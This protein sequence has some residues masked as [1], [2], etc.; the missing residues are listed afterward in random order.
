M[1]D[2][3]T[4]AGHKVNKIAAAGAGIGLAV[5][6]IYLYRRHQASAAAAASSAPATSTADTSQIDP[7]TGYPYGSPEDQAALQSMGTGYGYG[8][9]GG[10]GDTGGPLP[11]TGGG[12]TTNAQWTQAVEQ[13]FGSDG[14]DAIGA[15]LGKYIA[16][17]PVTSDQAT[18]IEQAIAAEGNPPVNGPEG[19]PPS[20]KLVSGGGQATN[21]V[22][23]LKVTQGGTTGVDISWQASSGATTYKVTTSKGTVENTGATSARIR[24]I[25][26]AGHPSSATVTVLAQPAAAGANP[27][28]ITVHTSK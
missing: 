15:A 24:S 6:A 7:E 1:A 22:T 11:T 23:G 8:T 3:I 4:I 17:L 10:G 16:G 26:P 21:P 25:N 27:A 12:F 18:I 19:M 13:Y 2:T 28:T 9:Y 14:T 5:V 20:F